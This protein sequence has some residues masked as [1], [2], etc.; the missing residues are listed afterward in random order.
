MPNRLRVQPGVVWKLLAH[1]LSGRLLL[2]TLL[3]VMVSEVTIFVPSIGRFYM[4]E[5]NQ[6]IET[7]EIAILPFTEPGSREFSSGLRSQLL[8]R[9]DA[10]VVI[11]KRA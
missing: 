7:A 9:A 11:L 2:L 8:A 4:G 10:T 3:Y 6:H 5:L 1:S